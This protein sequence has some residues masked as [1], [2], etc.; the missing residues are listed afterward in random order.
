MLFDAALSAY[1]IAFAASLAALPHRAFFAN[2]AAD[3]GDGEGRGAGSAG[4]DDE[5]RDHG[6]PSRLPARGPGAGTRAWPGLL[7][8]AACIGKAKAAAGAAP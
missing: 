4:A 1:L 5:S 3:A 2:A 7:A 8:A 6:P